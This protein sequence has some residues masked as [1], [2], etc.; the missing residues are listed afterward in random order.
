MYECD[1]V[2]IKAEWAH[3]GRRADE[4]SAARIVIQSATAAYSWSRLAGIQWA[5]VDAIERVSE[6]EI[7]Q[8]NI[9]TIMVTKTYIG[10]KK[11]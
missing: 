1:H 5:L 6:T 7:V 4:N 9:I 10:Y 11:K 3:R 2:R 8:I